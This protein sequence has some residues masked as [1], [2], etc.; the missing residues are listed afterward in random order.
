MNESS[1]KDERTAEF[2]TEMFGKPREQHRWLQQLLGEWTHETADGNAG[3]TK[4]TGTESVRAMGDLW[5]LAEGTGEMPDGSPATTLMTLG[6]NP[7]TKR[8]VGTWVGSMMSHLWVYDGE[9]D[10]AG[11]VLTLNAEGPSMAGD[12][13]MALYQ[14]II[15]LKSD[16][17]RTLTAQ[18]QQPDG[19]WKQFMTMDYRRK[20]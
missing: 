12:G 20:R 15:E 8:F 5:V 14:D 6:Y 4:A 7:A 10:A 11:R 13:T 17:H 18:V 3:G 16:N 1:L 9:L 2:S 19:T